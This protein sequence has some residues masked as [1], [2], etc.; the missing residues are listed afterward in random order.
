[1]G[2][3]KSVPSGLRAKGRVAI[4]TGAAS[5][6]GCQT[7]LGLAYAGAKVA[8]I[9]RLPHG[10]DT[11]RLIVDAGGEATFVQ[12]DV[13]TPGVLAELFETTCSQLGPVDILLN[14]AVEFP[15]HGFFEMSLGQW[16]DTFATNLHAPLVAMRTVLPLMISRG[17]GVIVNMIAPSGLAHAADM[18]A[19]KAALRSLL[20]SLAAEI[21]PSAGVQVF[22]FLPALVA[23]PLVK[24][25][26]S[27]YAARLGLSFAEYVAT[28]RPNPGYEGLMPAEHCAASLVH[29]IVHAIDHHG[30]IVVPF[31]PLFAAGIIKRPSDPPMLGGDEGL[32]A[33][34]NVDRLRNYV[35]DIHSAD[36]ELDRQ[37]QQRTL[38]LQE[39]LAERRIAE[40]Q[41]QIA[42][43]EL[44]KAHDNL[45][46]TQECLHQS[47]TLAAMG[48][49]AGGVAH[50]FN[51][52]LMVILSSAGAVLEDLGKDH[53]AATELAHIIEAG[54]RSK[55]LTKQLLTFSGKRS[56]A[57]EV[58]DL[59]EVVQATH[60]LLKRRIGTNITIVL[61]RKTT[62]VRVLMD[63]RQ[64]EQVLLNLGVNARDAMPDGG[65]LCFQ[66]EGGWYGAEELNGA[67]LPG[68]SYAKLT[69]RDTGVG[70]SSELQGRAFE[71]FFTTKDVGEGIGMGLAIVHGIVRSVGGDI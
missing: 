13:R 59:S 38:E 40:G 60:G 52:M 49:L 25:V 20:I 11:A 41:A 17:A 26:F 35:R 45:K 68:G 65:E 58:L 4:V 21:Q 18:S 10:A 14:N 30:R 7:A 69:V 37:V 5:G 31:E 8:M 33:I 19:S 39:Q 67:D 57:P 56:V 54:T 9:D 28:M 44:E 48:Q 36:V 53:P 50:D 16:E 24:A 66:I 47:E 55:E 29:S 71:R 32:A 43:R 12:G 6:I 23:T 51:E 1:M 3:C 46:K 15:I 61:E 63:R 27:L 70:M 64:L 42:L 34:T 62:G 22:G 2:S